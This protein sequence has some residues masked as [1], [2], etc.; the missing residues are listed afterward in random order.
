[1]SV[2]SPVAAQFEAYN[3]HDIDSFMAFFAEDFKAIAC[4][5]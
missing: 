2:I 4:P 1:M 5:L 3:A